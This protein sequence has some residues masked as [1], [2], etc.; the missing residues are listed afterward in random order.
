MRFSAPGSEYRIPMRFARTPRSG[1]KNAKTPA[2]RLR[3]DHHATEERLPGKRRDENACR[4]RGL[5]DVSPSGTTPDTCACI[6]ASTVTQGA[7]ALRS[8]ESWLPIHHGHGVQSSNGGLLFLAAGCKSGGNETEPRRPRSGRLFSN[9]TAKAPA[10]PQDVN[11]GSGR[12]IISLF[13]NQRATD[14][15]AP[16]IVAR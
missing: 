2:A 4:G 6:N 14:M 12:S 5:K 3:T 9:A 10:C 13:D 16:I 15:V 8:P 11:S 1:S 7:S